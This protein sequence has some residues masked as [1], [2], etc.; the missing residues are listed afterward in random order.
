M[1]GNKQDANEAHKIYLPDLETPDKNVVLD[2]T[3]GQM[4]SAYPMQD[5]ESY[6]DKL[7]LGDLVYEHA[8]NK[9]GLMCLR[10]AKLELLTQTGVSQLRP[11][12]EDE[13]F[14]GYYINEVPVSYRIT[15]AKGEKYDITVSSKVD[16]DN[17]GLNIE[18]RK[19]DLQIG[20]ENNLATEVTLSEAD[21]ANLLS[22]F[23]TIGT[24]CESV[25]SA[26]NKGD[27][28]TAKKLC[29]S[30]TE[31]TKKMK[32]L[33]KSTE[34]EVIVTAGANQFDLMHQ[35]L[36]EGNVE[37]A[38]TYVKVIMQLG[39]NASPMFQQL[40][41]PSNN[42][43]SADNQS[44]NIAVNT[45][46]V[47]SVRPVQSTSFEGLNI[48]FRAAK[49]HMSSGE[50]LQFI[51]NVENPSNSTKNLNVLSK[52]RPLFTEN[53]DRKGINPNIRYCPVF[54]VIGPDLPDTLAPGGQASVKY[55][56]TQIAEF[57][58]P[59]IKEEVRPGEYRVGMGYLEGAKQ[60]PVFVGD[61]LMVAIIPGIKNRREMSP[62]LTDIDIKS[63]YE[64]Y[65]IK[66]GFVSAATEIELG[67]KLII[68]FVVENRSQKEFVFDF[69]GDYRVLARPD[70]FKIL[71]Y[72]D[73]GNLLPDVKG[74]DYGMLPDPTDPNQWRGGGKSTPRTV[75]ADDMWIETIDVNDFRHITEPGIYKI[76]CRFVLNPNDDNRKLV[77]NEFML[78]VK[79]NSD[80]N[81][82][83]SKSK[84]EFRI[85][86]DSVVSS[87]VPSPLA[88]EE[89]KK[90][91]DDLL[92]NG[93]EAGIKRNDD[94][95]WLPV[96]D[97]TQLGFLVS[98][99]YN[100]KKYLLVSNKQSSVMLSDGSWNVEKAYITQYSDG[101]FAGISLQ[102]DEKGG[103][104]LFQLTSNNIRKALAAIIDGKV[105]SAPVIQSA[106]SREAMITGKF[107]E[108]QAN[109]MISII[110][111]SVSD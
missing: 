48:L 110:N 98:E 39:N 103:E 83:K 78:T 53:H 89:E 85:A 55:E 97:D 32:A 11:D 28:E 29:E 18:Y 54:E 99:E 37:S 15:T 8:Q 82:Q 106:I 26:I 51:L 81:T 50:N 34:F 46:T 44:K 64:N 111:G 92:K 104:K 35:A 12:T 86:P 94:Y 93:H 2:F 3:T 14:T 66:A 76:I 19:A 31:V 69:G 4:L 49:S 79:S 33:A 84:V 23:I 47:G 56:M 41:N 60:T 71:V 52:L 6:F 1:G 72:D 62:Y 5:D 109:S 59:G 21:K 40:M 74:D 25:E 9:G 38:K 70:R 58:S 30:I 57:N 24:T 36:K 20:T 67:Q 10:G 13:F 17:G 100:G 68:S 102:L 87:R 61:K 16:G 75:L 101:R 107:T 73:K 108:E 42:N 90:Y 45:D 88:Q 65:K 96:R 95:I 105:I 43:T 91:K 22:M 77:E 7:G 63:G 80:E 27:I